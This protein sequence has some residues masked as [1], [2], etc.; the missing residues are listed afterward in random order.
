MDRQCGLADLEGLR[1]VARHEQQA[2]I[3]TLGALRQRMPGT[4]H[5]VVDGNTAAKKR[6]GLTGL[7]KIPQEAQD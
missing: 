1:R 3:L 7:P 5:L 4:E 6:F 2:R